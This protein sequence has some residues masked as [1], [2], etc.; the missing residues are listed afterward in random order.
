MQPSQQP[1]DFVGHDL[2]RPECVIGHASGI[3]LVPDWTGDGGLSVIFP[4][5]SVK[6]HLVRNAPF[7]LRPNGIALLQGG[8]VLLVHLGAEDGGVWRLKP[9]GTVD[10]EIGEVDGEPM[11][12]SNFCHVDWQGRRWISVSTRQIPRASAY[13]RTV[14]DGYIVLADE[15]GARI[16]AEDLGY[17]NECLVHPDGRRLFVNETFSRRL[18]CFDIA[19]N[20]E[21]RNR[22]TVTEFTA[23]TF[24]DGM[25]FDENGDVWIVSIVSN[26]V[27][28]VDDKGR[29]SLV[30]E[31]ADADFVTAAEQAYLADEMGRPHLDNNPAPNLRNISSMAFDG[32]DLSR[33]VFGCLL[34]EQLPVLQAPVRGWTMPHF[35]YDIAPLLHALETVPAVVGG[36]NGGG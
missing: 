29:Q 26:R 1:I 17:T 4:D 30:L 35:H 16:V 5:G 22:R 12:P 8:D 18:T 31:D 32:P 23:G 15:R 25:A 21:L 11:P 20:G 19:E 13:N 9:D 7:E 33:I 3:L 36:G 34:G 6:R 2:R 27:I 24:P 28:R 10:L 14:C